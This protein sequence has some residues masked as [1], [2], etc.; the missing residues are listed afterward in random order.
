MCE[1][2]FNLSLKF[3]QTCKAS[4]QNQIYDDNEITVGYGIK[5]YNDF[6]A[7]VDPSH[8]YRGVKGYFYSKDIRV[9]Y[10]TSLQ[11]CCIPHVMSVKEQNLTLVLYGWKKVL[12]NQT[13][14]PC[15]CQENQLIRLLK[16]HMQLDG[17]LKGLEIWVMLVCTEVFHNDLSH[18][19][20]ICLKLQDEL[21]L[22]DRNGPKVFTKCIQDQLTKDSCNK[23]NYH[24]NYDHRYV[25]SNSSVMQKYTR[26]GVI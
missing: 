5:N 12:R 20:D 22:T 11:L 7:K 26:G 25:K 16:F 3:L 4:S 24:P 19:N 2:T 6:L 10:L 1:W 8:I 17:E 15:V 9:C 23:L 13:W 18:T 14:C 21:C